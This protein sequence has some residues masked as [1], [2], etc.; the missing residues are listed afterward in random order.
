MGRHGK[1]VAARPGDERSPSTFCALWETESKT[2][3]YLGF[4]DIGDFRRF[5]AS[6]M[7][8]LPWQAYKDLGPKPNRNEA[9]R[10]LRDYD[11]TIF[12]IT[13]VE[14]AEKWPLNCDAKLQK[15]NRSHRLAHLLVDMKRE[16]VRTTERQR[17]LLTKN[18]NEE[19]KQAREE[20]DRRVAMQRASK[21]YFLDEQKKELPGIKLWHIPLPSLGPFKD[22][23]ECELETF[24][25]LFHVI[26]S[27]EYIFQLK[28]FDKRFTVGEMDKRHRLHRNT[29]LNGCGPQQHPSPYRN[30]QPSNGQ[31]LFHR[32]T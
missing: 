4:T 24:N 23:E 14:A 26:K 29:S 19:K 6:Y 13:A 22:K 7:A 18:S 28:I 20:S 16:I 12:H 9:L 30:Q 2:A 5:M 17:V 15:I 31:M 27:W 32:S 11:E 8:V 1:E 10:Y 25:R 3:A 21:Q